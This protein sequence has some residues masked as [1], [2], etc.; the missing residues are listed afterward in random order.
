[1]VKS[2]FLQ[3]LGESV[4]ELHRQDNGTGEVSSV[5]GG[6]SVSRTANAAIYIM[7]Q[8]ELGQAGL[9]HKV[10][11]PDLFELCQFL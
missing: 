4:D 7:E 6:P 10:Q 1:M 9:K 3:S 8:A 11:A 2:D 5:K